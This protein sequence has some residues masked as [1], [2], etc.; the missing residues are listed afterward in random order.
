M[1]ETTELTVVTT[2]KQPALDHM[3]VMDL[4]AAHERWETIRS[5]VARIMIDGE[6]YGVIPGTRSKPTL[7]KSG[8]EK[9]SAFFGLAPAF[10]VTQRIER[11]DDKE[12]FFHYEVTC[13]LHRGGQLRGEGLGSCN[14]RES[15]YRYRV[16]ER[17]CPQCGSASIIKGREEYG[18]GWICFPKKGGCGAKF[19][20][21]DQRIE[22]QEMGRVPNPD[23]ADTVNTIL[24][25]AKKRALIDAVLNTVGASQFFTQDVEDMPPA[26]VPVPPQQAQTRK[27]QKSCGTGSQI[28]PRSKPPSRGSERAWRPPW[29]RTRHPRNM[30]ALLDAHG[31]NQWQD[32]GTIQ[33]ARQFAADLHTLLESESVQP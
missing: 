32:L 21:G 17:K 15:K 1:L 23:I 13:R 9:L 29:A 33:K 11:W 26:H 24:K 31:V 19:G 28:K 25:M 7:L 4:E 27:A 10:E 6:D 14:S 18:G 12:P 3:P 30:S 22:S 8:A 5:F 2:P 16:A 20:D